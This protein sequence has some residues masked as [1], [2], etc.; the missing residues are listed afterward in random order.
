MDRLCQ[1]VESFADRFS[2][3]KEGDS[4]LA[5]VSGG[6]DSVCL[7]HVLR[8]L[9]LKKNFRLQVIHVE[10]GIRGAESEEDMAFVRDLCGSLGLPFYAERLDVPKLALQTGRTL[11]EAAREARYSVFYKEAVRLHA[12]KVAVAHNRGDLAETVLWNLIRGSSINGLKGMRP[13]R[14]LSA[15][16][17]D[18]LLIRPVLEL[19]REEIEKW[20]EEKGIGFRMDRTNSDQEITRNRMRLTVL[21]V[22]R[23]LNGQTDAHIAQAAE[24]M[25]EA[26]EYLSLQAEEAF[27]RCVKTGGNEKDVYSLNI[28]LELF[29]KE[30]LILQKRVLRECIRRLTPKGSLKD[31]GRVH[32]EELIT[33]SRQDC[34]KMVCLPRGLRAVREHGNLH[35]FRKEG[36]L[37]QPDSPDPIVIR[38]EGDYRFGEYLFRVSFGQMPEDCPGA[39]LGSPLMI[40]EKVYKKMLAYDTIGPNLCLRS[41]CSGDY[42]TV[43]GGRQ[44]LKRYLI[45]SKYPK[46]RRDR[47]PLLAQGSHILWAVGG[48]ISEEAKLKAGSYYICIECLEHPEG[49]FAGVPV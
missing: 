6:A 42:L 18:I 38:E 20:L 36:T 43:R 41:R 24:E 5:G 13:V 32:L 9:S 12:G 14:L 48:K 26:E 15:G 30:P 25:N 46:D 8:E 45:D 27:F 39:A 1:R 44:K 28:G 40:E 31:I 4:V 7:L 34:G 23:E 49:A 19:S 29:L 37:P 17:E 11:E 21:P 35:F 33:L 10:H 47:L 2:M 22:L 3:L 16:R